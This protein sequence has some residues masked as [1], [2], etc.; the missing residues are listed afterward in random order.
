MGLLHL[1]TVTMRLNS[2]N[3]SSAACAHPVPDHETGR[4]DFQP[5]IFFGVNDADL[6]VAAVGAELT[7]ARSA[8]RLVSVPAQLPDD[9]RTELARVVSVKALFSFCGGWWL[10]AMSAR[11]E[12]RHGNVPVVTFISWRSVPCRRSRIIDTIA[13]K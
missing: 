5:S 12:T 9:S 8:H 4:Y 2:I 7:A 13:S 6:A 3:T 10:T 1:P 11:T